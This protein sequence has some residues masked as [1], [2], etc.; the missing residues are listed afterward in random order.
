MLLPAQRTDKQKLASVVVSL[1]ILP[2]FCCCYRPSTLNK[3]LES[4]DSIGN[5]VAVVRT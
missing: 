1:D 3:S 2:L 5:E 4:D